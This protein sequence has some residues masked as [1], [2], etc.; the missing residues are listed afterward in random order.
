ME[1]R[2]MS[3]R[4]VCIGVA[5]ATL[6]AVQPRPAGAATVL[7]RAGENLQAAINTAQPG[8]TILLEA[9]ATFRGNFTLPVKPGAAYITIRTS[10]ADALLPAPGVRISPAHAAHLPTIE[11]T[12]SAPALRTMAGSH[13]WRLQLLHFPST[14]LGYGEIIRIGEG[15]SAQSLLSQVPYEIDIDR[16]YIHGHT[17]YGQKRG[18]ALNGRS[19]T[20]RN[21]HISDIKAVGMDTQAI[22]GWN[23]PGPFLVENNFLEA[24]GE[25]FLL[26]GSDP[27]IPNLVS[28]GV[29]VRDNYMTRPMSW[30]DPVVP[31]P[32]SVS[33]SVRPGAGALPAGTYAYQVIARRPVGSGTIGRSTASPEARSVIPDGQSGAVAISWSPVADATEYRVYGARPDGTRFY[34]TVTGTSF[35]DTGAGGTPGAVPTSQGETWQVKNIF[36]LKNARNVVVAYNVFENNWKNAQPGYAI[37]FTPRNQDGACTWC[38][39]ENVTFEY[40]IVRNSGGGI[41]LTG[42]DWPNASGRTTNVKIRHNLFYNITRDLGGS[43]W[44]LLI[45]DEPRDI[46]VDHN[47]VDID[48][49][50][51]VYVYGGTEAAPKQVPGLQFT[52]NAVQHKSYGINGTFF[53]WGNGILAGYFPGAIVQGNWLQGGT[54]SRYPAGNLFNGTFEAAFVD[55][56]AGDYRPAP[57][58]VLLGR[59]TDGTNIGA[60]VS[61]VLAGVRGV[62]EG[63]STDSKRPSIPS[64]VRVVVK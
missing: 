17:L 12:N 21:S 50:A 40:N 64:N 19:V 36:E 16:V 56:A 33:A 9:G 62:V 52:N 6:M 38:V 47:T 60:D 23:G 44:F 2:T 45:G 58:S 31:A 25:N 32:G 7:V 27:A 55:A 3:L 49:S 35:T 43:G 48:G 29:V 37:L 61:A 15:S 4:R 22:G 13:H 41:N 14:H 42:Y 10:A 26:G 34:W 51:A 20:I 53:G 8:D 57:G 5:L 46:V 1:L 39:I 24:S 28:E 63:L 11:S 59:A 18:I 30:R 54:A